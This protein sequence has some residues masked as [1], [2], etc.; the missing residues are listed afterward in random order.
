VLSLKN[1]VTPSSHFVIEDDS[2]LQVVFDSLENSSYPVEECYENENKIHSLVNRL[3]EF[4]TD[5]NTF[6]SKNKTIPEVS[7]R[8]VDTFL[9]NGEMQSTRE[10][11]F[12]N[13]L[14]WNADYYKKYQTYESVLENAAQLAEENYE[15]ER[16][17]LIYGDL[18][19]GNIGLMNK[20]CSSLT[21][22]CVQYLII[23]TISQ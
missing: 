17:Q 22:K 7:E 23:C 1:T 18:H 16:E 6:Y 21:G 9:E 19:L 3:V 20:N 12:D 2:S 8:H 10:Y 13:R 15:S 4:R 11:F 14:T 5:L